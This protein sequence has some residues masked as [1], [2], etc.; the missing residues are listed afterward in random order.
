M[1]TTEQIIEQ[2]R[3]LLKQGHTCVGNFRINKGCI[4]SNVYIMPGQEEADLPN[5]KIPWVFTRMYK[6]KLEDPNFKF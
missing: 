5:G 4:K 3:E 1:R 6:Y 2:I